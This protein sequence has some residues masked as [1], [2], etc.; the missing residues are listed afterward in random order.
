MAPFYDFKAYTLAG[1]LQKGIIEAD[2]QKSARA[3]LKKQGLMVSEMT[4]KFKRF[5]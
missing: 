5:L 1:K 3:K 2:S 4:E